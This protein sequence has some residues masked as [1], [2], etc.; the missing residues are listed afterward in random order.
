MP[1]T[2]NFHFREEWRE[3]KRGR[4]GHR[5]Q[6]RYERA[7]CSQRKACATERICFLI[8][9]LLALAVGVVLVVIPG[10]AIPFFFLGG[11]F[12]AKESR[13]IARLMD[14]SEIRIREVVAWVKPRWKRL[15]RGLRITLMLLGAGCSAASAYLLFRLTRG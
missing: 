5:F 13:G 1:A 14:W 4:P 8:A 2:V 9:G 6:D 12:L 3:I 7:H 11:A 15:P 10:P